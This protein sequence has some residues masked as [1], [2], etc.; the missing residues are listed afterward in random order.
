[1]KKSEL[2]RLYTEHC[3]NTAPDMDRIWEKIENGLE[4]K[5]ENRV[6]SKPVRR[7]SFPKMAI[8]GTALAAVLIGV[9]AAL[10][11]SNSAKNF[12]GMT[13]ENAAG[14]FYAMDGAYAE[15]EVPAEEFATTSSMPERV[16]YGDLA[17]RPR[18]TVEQYPPTPTAEP[19]GDEF[20][21]EEKVLAETD[22]IVDAVVVD[23]VYNSK[24]GTVTYSLSSEETGEIKV[25]SASPYVLKINGE[26][27]LPLK[28]TEE[29]YRLTFENAPQI[30][31][32]LDGGLVFHNGWK[33]LENNSCEVV[34]GRNGVDDF[35]YDR[36][37]FSYV[38]WAALNE[39]WKAVKNE[40]E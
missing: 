40:E 27:V 8:L 24:G 35:F 34:Y 7:V 36:M 17:V 30:E 15:E 28:E 25:E 13:A 26:Y 31:C 1:M 37:R 11:G 23:A 10:I 3:E 16:Y 19:F 22:I 9:P 6:T 33:C 21:V 18:T 12:D 14:D 2:K 32:T 4:D 39:R 29:G 20:F 38:D 5:P